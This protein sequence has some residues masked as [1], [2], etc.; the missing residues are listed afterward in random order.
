MSGI[1]DEVEDKTEDVDEA[2]VVA[3][4]DKMRLFTVTMIDGEQLDIPAHYHDIAECGHLIFYTKLP[5]GTIRIRHII[6]TNAWDNLEEVMM[7]AGN[8]RGSRRIN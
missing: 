3:V 6:N 1:Y 5:D 4:A 8:V 2:A 7:E